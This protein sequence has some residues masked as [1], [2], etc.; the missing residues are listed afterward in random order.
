MSKK[1]PVVTT[2][3]GIT[4]TP[5]MFEVIKRWQPESHLDTVLPQVYVGYL[6]QMQD[7][8]CLMIGDYGDSDQYKEQVAEIT[9]HMTGLIHI[10]KDLEKFI[11]R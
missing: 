11:L 10:K 4:L 3:N 9:S 2:I 8:L 7:F 5:D 1:D 6:T